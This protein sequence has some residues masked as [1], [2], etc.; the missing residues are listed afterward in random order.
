MSSARAECTD[1]VNSIFFLEQLS[2]C[3]QK[4]RIKEEDSLSAVLSARQE[5]PS[6]A[7]HLFS[8]T[9][10]PSNHLTVQRAPTCVQN[11]TKTNTLKQVQLARFHTHVVPAPTE[12]RQVDTCEFK[13][14]LVSKQ[15]KEK[16]NKKTRRVYSATCLVEKTLLKG[17]EGERRDG[18]TGDNGLDRLRQ[19]GTA[20]PVPR[21]ASFSQGPFILPETKFHHDP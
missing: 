14:S 1:S 5:H 11:Q 12:Q 4:Q 7:G 16:E 17:L 6:T 20:V 15:E 18:A 21:Q 10:L 19:K 8:S 2:C 3:L 13:A 9:P